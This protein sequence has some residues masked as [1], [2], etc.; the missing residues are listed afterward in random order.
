MVNQYMRRIFTY[1]VIWLVVFSLVISETKQEPIIREYIEPGSIEALIN[2]DTDYDRLM[3]I[4]LNLSNDS[5]FTIVDEIFPNLELMGGPATYHRVFPIDDFRIL[6]ESVSYPTYNILKDPYNPPDISRDYWIEIK[7]GSQTHGTY[8]EDDAI[9]YTC[10]CLSGASDCVKLGW[11]SWYNPLDYW[12][13]AWWSFSPPEHSSINEIRVNVRGG[14]C[15]DLPLWSETY[16]GMRDENGSW[17]QDYE[18][19][20]NYTDNLFVVPEVWNEGML[21]PII[22][23]E[24]NYVI[25][26]ITLQFFYSCESS[27]SPSNVDAS[28]GT[29]CDHIDVSWSAPEN[30]EG[31]SGYNLYRDGQLVTEFDSNAFSFSDYGV[32]DNNQHEYCLASI[33]EC[34]ESE[35]SCNMGSLMENPN[36]VENVIASDGLYSDYVSISWNHSDNTDSYK[37][38]RDGIWL[39]VLSSSSEPEYIDYY[40][41][42]ETVH[43]YCNEST[44]ECGT[45]EWV[46]DEGYGA[47]GIGD[48]NDDD[49]VDVLDVVVLVNIIMG[50]TVPDDDEV[51]AADI[52]ND[53]QINIQDIVLLVTIIL[54]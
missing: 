44:N 53:G 40:I 19:S 5:L 2:S 24:D 13:E 47:T 29:H 49:F 23:S 45:S 28:D 34:G 43:S 26:E 36:E 18:L 50:Y 9:S 41:E 33:N 46:C 6:E 15:D 8:T 25:D 3:L 14:Q 4:Q 1:K 22:G 11:Y 51:W 52:N 32:N 16:M 37:I 7:Q 30:Q 54:D 21:M 20:I 48:I 12:G 38:Y 39:G 27:A 35:F 42:L 17:S 31:I 10:D